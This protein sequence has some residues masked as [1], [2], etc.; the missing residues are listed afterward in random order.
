MAPHFHRI[1]VPVDFSEYS[2]R[3]LRQ[4]VTLAEDSGATVDILHVWEPPWTL[5]TDAVTMMA[6]AVDASV[7][8]MELEQAERDL[9]E[10]VEP[11][12]GSPVT[13]GARLEHGPV[14]DTLLRVMREG[15]YDL[16]VIGTHG[17]KGL[18]RLVLGSVAEQVAKRA[19]CAVLTVPAE[20]EDVEQ[21]SAP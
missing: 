17:R 8:R 6:G 11:Y 9:K 15:K 12:Q 4:A 10:W 14:T 7:E 3:A 2:R 5:N 21:P 13:V 19:G 20:A 1:L 16:V 18:A